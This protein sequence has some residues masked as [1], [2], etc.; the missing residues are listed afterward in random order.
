MEI[1]NRTGIIVETIELISEFL[2]RTVKIDFYLPVHIGNPAEIS[3]LLINDGQD[4][5]TIGFDKLLDKLHQQ[6][7]I[8]PLICAGIHC[9][10]DRK[11]EYGMMSSVDYKGRGAK[12]PQYHRFI[13]EELLPHIYS[14]YALQSVKEKAFAGF[15][16]GGLSALDIVWNHPDVFQKA[17]VFSGSLWWRI[18]DRNDKDFNENTDRLMHRQIRRGSF[19]PGLQFFFQCGELDEGEDRNR[20]GV[21]DSIDDTIDVMRELLAKGYLEGKDMQYLQLS[22]GKHD[23]ASWARS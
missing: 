23:V 18:K 2:E 14:Q 1:E 17:G 7:L 21:I 16:L 19:H 12:A 10:E 8:R 3:L 6:L 11:S 15:S 9:G 4:L 22:D 5:V 13:F 20:N